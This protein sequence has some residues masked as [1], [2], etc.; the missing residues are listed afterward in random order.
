M[1]LNKQLLTFNLLLLKTRVLSST[2]N[3][4]SP[5]EQNFYYVNT[6]SDAVFMHYLIKT[7]GL[8]SVIVNIVKGLQSLITRTLFNK[9]PESVIM[10]LFLF[11]T[12]LGQ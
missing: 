3:L 7:N 9:L 11:L 10:C 6:W 8:V 2:Y 5:V 4:F 12:P 1:F